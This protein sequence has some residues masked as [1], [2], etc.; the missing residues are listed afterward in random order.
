MSDPARPLLERQLVELLQA[1]EPPAASGEHDTILDLAHLYDLQ[2]ASRHCDLAARWLRSQGKGYYTIGSAG[3]ESNAIL[4]MVTRPTD[5]AL[6]HYR[7]G[8]FYLGRAGLDGVGDILAGVVAAT[9]EPVSGGRDKVFGRHDLAI[10]PQTSTIASH[11]PR[12]VGVAFAIDRASKLKVLSPWPSDAITVCSFG[13]ASTNHAV[14]AAAFNTAAYCSYQRLPMPLLFVCEDNGL[15][16]SVRT[17]TGWIE[18]SFASRPNLR[19]V[20]VN[21]EDPVEVA[22]VATDLAGWV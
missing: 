10:I 9:R 6:L 22:E 15:G 13:D 4:A 18:T 21:G 12:A 19:Y 1:L 3:H 16:I 7:S 8:A 2:L 17:P 14:A 11:L 20:A 5:P